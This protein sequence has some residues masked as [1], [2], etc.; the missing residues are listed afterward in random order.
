LPLNNG[1]ELYITSYVEHF[2]AKRTDDA[3]ESIFAELD[4]ESE[5]LQK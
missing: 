5:F 4:K 1:S 2:G 3:V